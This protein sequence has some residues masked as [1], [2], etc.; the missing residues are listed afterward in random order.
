[1]EKKKKL[2][3]VEG[4]HGRNIPEGHQEFTMFFPDCV[5]CMDVPLRSVREAVKR[6][7]KVKQVWVLRTDTPSPRS[8]GL[9]NARA[10]RRAS[11]LVESNVSEIS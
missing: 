3:Q 8:T 2:N 7:D 9:H 6:Y 1:M 5:S 11:V 10:H 4:I